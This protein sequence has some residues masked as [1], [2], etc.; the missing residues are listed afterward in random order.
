MGELHDCLK[1]AVDKQLDF[2]QLISAIS[3]ILD[4]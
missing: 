3:A 2:I 1:E 4:D